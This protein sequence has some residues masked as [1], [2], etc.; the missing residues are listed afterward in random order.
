MPRGRPKGGK[1]V[2]GRRKGTPNKTTVAVKAA[3]TSAFTQLGGVDN[4]V[5]W[6]KDNPGEF[7]KLWAKLLPTEVKL[8][9]EPLHLEI[10]ERIVSAGAD[11]TNSLPM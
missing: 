5:T 11:R 8:E 10:V 4:L 2:G 7:F 1:K 6:G 9:A 3:L